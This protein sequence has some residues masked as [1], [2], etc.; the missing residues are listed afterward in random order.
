M[1]HVEDVDISEDSDRPHAF[2]VFGRH[3]DYNEDFIAK[4]RKKPAV[5]MVVNPL[6][7]AA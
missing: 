6:S 1:T 7:E 4:K 2:I 5:L 3:Q